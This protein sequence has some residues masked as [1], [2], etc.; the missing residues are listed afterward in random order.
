MTQ[1]N[2]SIIVLLLG[3]AFTGVG[4]AVNIALHTRHATNRR[5]VT[6]RDVADEFVWWT[7]NLGMFLIAWGIFW[8][9]K[10]VVKGIL[11]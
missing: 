4:L 2:I 8:L 11:R 3:C 9:V 5:F 1:E 7:V 6:G 10:P